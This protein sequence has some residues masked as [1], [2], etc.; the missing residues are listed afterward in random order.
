M[1]INIPDNIQYGIQIINT[2]I[3]CES[4]KPSSLPMKQLRL[5]GEMV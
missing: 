4:V 3:N 5:H 1:K 2:Y